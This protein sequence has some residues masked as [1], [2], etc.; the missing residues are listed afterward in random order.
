[1]KTIRMLTAALAFVA[2]TSAAFA[3]PIMVNHKEA[4]IRNGPATSY[5]V[6]WNPRLYT[7]VEVLARYK[8]W[9]AVRDVEGDVGWIHD[10][11]VAKNAAAIVTDSLVNVYESADAKSRVVYQAPKNY[12]FKI[13]EKK[14]EWFR[15]T[16]PDND[17]GWI[18]AKGVWTGGEPLAK[19]DDK[20]EAKKEDKKEEKKESKKESKKKDGDSKPKKKSKKEKEKE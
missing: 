17:A 7:P 3:E 13:E 16:D 19:G 20:E 10:S 14:G 9:S 5:T 2:G 11:A 6:L 4:K 12:T 1:M 8:D 18:T 15:V